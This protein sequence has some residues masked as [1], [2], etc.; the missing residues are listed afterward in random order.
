MRL[1]REIGFREEGL[2]LLGQ[3]AAVRGSTLELRNEALA[4]LAQ[5]DLVVESRFASIPDAHLG[6]APP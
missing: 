6:A 3:A 2:K 5:S 1:R 4:N